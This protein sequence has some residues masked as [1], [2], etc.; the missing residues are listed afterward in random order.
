MPDIDVDFFDRARILSLIEHTTASRKDGPSLK[1][2]NTGIYVTDIPR[3]HNNLS[4]ID[5]QDAESR[6]YFKI[7]FLNAGVYKDIEDEE[8]LMRLLEIEPLW[9]LLEQDDFVDL[10]YHINGYSWLLRKLKPNSIE[11]LAAILALIRPAKKHLIDKTWSEILD[12]VWIKPVNDEYYFKKSHAIAYASA[13]VVQ[14]NLICEKISIG[15]S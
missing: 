7:D 3:D 10:L 1:P 12:Q 13:I 5:Y 8:H 9:D 14:M 6:G 2:H 11:K 4:T 15:Y